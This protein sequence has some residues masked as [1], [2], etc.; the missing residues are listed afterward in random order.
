MDLEVF[1][2]IGIEPGFPNLRKLGGTLKE[3]A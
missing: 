3:V 1:G 2:E